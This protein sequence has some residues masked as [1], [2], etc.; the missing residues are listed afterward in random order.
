M[1]CK[2]TLKNLALYLDGELDT[3]K[4]QEILS[5]FHEC[6]HCSDVKE[7]EAKLKELIREKLAY[8]KKAPSSITSAI[9]QIVYQES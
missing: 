6:W 9:K 2:E 3:V 8:S 1:D 5:H 7:S 4:E